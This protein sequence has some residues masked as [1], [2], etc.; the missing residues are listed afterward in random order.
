MGVILAAE[1][2]AEA[3][4]AGGYWRLALVLAGIGVLG[5]IARRRKARQPP[6]LDV[7]EFRARDREPDRYRDASDQ[8]LVEL[9]ETGREI[10]AGVDNKI[11]MLNRLVKDAGQLVARLEAL[12]RDAE[13]RIARLEALTAAENGGIAPPAPRPAGNAEAAEAGDGRRFRSNLQARVVALRDEGKTAAEITAA[14]GLSTIE[15]Q[16]ALEHADR[17]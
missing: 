15:I 11:R 7:K 6:P 14:T 13:R 3:A 10:N 5:L 1:P 17:A 9:I 2:V 4:A 12:M 8:A 16:L